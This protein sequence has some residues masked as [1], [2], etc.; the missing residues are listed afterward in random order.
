MFRQNRIVIIPVKG[1]ISSEGIPSLPFP[2][3]AAMR[4]TSATEII[5]F[6]EEV[7]QNKKVKAVILE[8]N[9]P[10]GTPFPSREIAEA[11]KKVEKPTVAW[12]K[13]YATSGAYWV[14]SAC[15]VVVAD[16]LSTV[17]SIGVM[18]IRPDLS[19]LMKKFGVDVNAVSSGIHKLFGLPFMKPTSEEKE[20][21]KQEIDAIQK[22]FI[23]E[24]ASNRKL[25][26]EAIECVSTGKVFMGRE[27]KSLG[28]VDYLG[29]KE[30][31]IEVAKEKAGITSYKLID[32]NQKMQK[33]KG[34]LPRLLGAYHSVVKFFL[35]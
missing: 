31:A 26:R 29:G 30:K 34:L 20:T 11:I 4:V 35:C 21:V 32:Y 7:K 24:V 1:T 12:V 22:E 8:I 13:E 14:A 10:G 3:P 23:E 25:T 27:A 17:G 9:S 5:K 18:S 2:L 33:P 16:A 19:E 6:L 28:L 15:D